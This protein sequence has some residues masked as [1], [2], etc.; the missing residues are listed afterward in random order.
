MTWGLTCLQG[1]V[2]A[3]LVNLEGFFEGLWTF[4]NCMCFISALLV[5][6]SH[7][8]CFSIITFL[9]SGSHLAVLGIFELYIVLKVLCINNE[10][11]SI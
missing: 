11:E 7:S 9:L 5:I 8:S 2:G 6:A 10:F 3:L 1:T 4:F